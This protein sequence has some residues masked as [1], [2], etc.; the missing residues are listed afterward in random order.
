MAEA[1]E[2]IEVQEPQPVVE[3]PVE[4]EVQTQVETPVD[5]GKPGGDDPQAVRARKEY[6]R[7]VKA[8]QETEAERLRVARLE[9]ELE[10]LKQK[11]APTAEKVYTMAEVNAAVEAGT[12]TRAQGDSY[13]QEHTLPN[14]FKQVLSARDAEQRQLQPL[15]KAE[16]D[17]EDYKRQIP[18]LNN[19]SDPKFVA[20]ANQ[21]H[22]LVADGLPENLVTQRVALEMTYGSLDKLKKKAEIEAQT[23]ERGANGMPVDT[24]AG[25]PKPTNGKVDVSKAPAHL[26]AYW[27]RTG[28]SAKDREAEMGYWMK[29]NAKK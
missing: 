17:I 24:G 11:P 13:I 19:K 27:D 22:R 23:R 16:A 12:I 9:G 10:A 28:T 29:K 8:E 3:T 25:G 4:T 6:G 5:E 1:A 2:T 21:Y 26:V 18:E 15:V 14:V 20:V 7:R